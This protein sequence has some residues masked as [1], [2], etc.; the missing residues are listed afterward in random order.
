MILL[1]KSIQENVSA[2][3]QQPLLGSDELGRTHAFRD[4]RGNNQVAARRKNIH[5][6]DH[7]LYGLIVSFIQ[8]IT[9]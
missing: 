9:R 6:C 5:R 3:R 8:R 1:T 7:P 2:H 4:F